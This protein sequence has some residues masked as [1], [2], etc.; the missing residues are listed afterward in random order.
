MNKIRILSLAM[1]LLGFFSTG[2]VKVDPLAEGSK[3]LQV[4]KNWRLD[5]KKFGT[6]LALNELIFQQ[7]KEVPLNINGQEK[8][9]RIAFKFLRPDYEKNFQM[10]DIFN[11]H[12]AENAVIGR[13]AAKLT[14]LSFQDENQIWVGIGR[15]YSTIFYMKKNAVGSLQFRFGIDVKNEFEMESMFQSLFS[16]ENGFDPKVPIIFMDA[17][18]Y[19]KPIKGAVGN[20]YVFTNLKGDVDYDTADEQAGKA[21]L[22]AQKIKAAMDRFNLK[23]AIYHIGS[24]KEKV[25]N[26]WPN[27]IVQTYPEFEE[28]QLGFIADIGTTYSVK[29]ANAKFIGQDQPNQVDDNTNL[30]TEFFGAGSDKY[31]YHALV[32]YYRKNPDPNVVNPIMDKIFDNIA[33]SVKKWLEANAANKKVKEQDVFYL[34]IRATGEL[35][36]LYYDS[37][38]KIASG[39]N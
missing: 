1:L 24:K 31:D 29:V 17:V 10:W 5:P 23:G 15:R 35:R 13:Q 21:G 2:C 27:H 3:P 39:L 25:L 6:F 32:E 38:E 7:S 18:S 20:E 19:A 34:I 26:K 8:K 4:R 16:L 9:L 22:M 36:E 14:G 11:H 30:I 28:G 37:L 33:E 12:R